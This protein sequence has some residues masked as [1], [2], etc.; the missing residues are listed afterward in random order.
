MR[1][2]KGN[3]CHALLDIDDNALSEFVMN[4]LV[5]FFD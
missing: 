5:T 3:L 1:I 2:G 4:D